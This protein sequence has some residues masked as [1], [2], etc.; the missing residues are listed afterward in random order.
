MNRLFKAIGGIDDRFISEQAEKMPLARQKNSYIPLRSKRSVFRRSAFA[1]ATAAVLISCFLFGN[2]LMNPTIG[3]AFVLKAYAMEQQQ[4]GTIAL[5]EVDLLDGQTHYWSTYS[6]GDVFYVSANLKCE[7]ENIESVDFYAADGFFAKQYLKVEN[8]VII[9]EEGVPAIYR[10][11]PGDTGYTITMYGEDFDIIGNAFT[12]K[13][14]ALTDDFLLFLG[15]T[16]SDWRERPS[17]MTVRAVATF[18]DGK[19]QEKTLTLNLDSTEAELVGTVKMPPEE[20]EKEMVEG[21]RHEE[22]VHSIPLEQ[23]E[24]VP[25]S[26][27]TLNYGDTFE[28][29]LDI[30]SDGASTVT[31][32]FTITEES[33]NPANDWSLK[34]DGFPGMFDENGVA[35][36]GAGLLSGL[37]REEYDGS[38][39]YI[40]VIVNNGNDTFAGKTYKVPGWLI[41]ENMK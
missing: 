13:K 14:D 3:N 29:S 6:D 17:E 26:E 11:A 5:R 41:L 32:Y 19:T 36:F 9:A 20:V 38:D 37:T 2:M 21:I 18:S 25:G 15:K 30:A 35:R 34:R 8:G 22:L 1:M 7:G 4:D 24:V 28:Y 40:S 16:I 33:M 23:C 10:M 12:L 31:G 27:V 39:G